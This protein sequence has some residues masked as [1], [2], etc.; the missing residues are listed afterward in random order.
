MKVLFLLCVSYFSVWAQ[1]VQYNDPITNSSAVTNSVSFTVDRYY[2]FF[3]N[4]D[5]PSTN[6][7]GVK[8]V[9]QDNKYSAVLYFRNQI[10][11]P[12]FEKSKNALHFFFPETYYQY[13]IR[14]LGE[15]GSAVVVYRE[16]K[17]GHNWGEVYFDKYP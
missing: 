3:G 5:K 16:Y 11:Y 13:I 1:Q 15:H 8:L 14:Q 6:E 4:S 9:D 12:S 10:N 7:Y 2:P 17:D